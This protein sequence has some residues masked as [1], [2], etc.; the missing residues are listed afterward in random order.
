MHESSMKSTVPSD[1]AL[2]LK[3]VRKPVNLKFLDDF[4]K[5]M[6]ISILD[7]AKVMNI[8][9]QGVYYWFIHDDAS[10][11]KMQELFDA[12]GYD[13]VVSLTRDK[14]EDNQANV[15]MKL[16]MEQEPIFGPRLDFLTKAI[17]TYK[18]KKAEV[19]RK[20]KISATTIYYWQT[21]DDCLLSNLFEFA[22]VTGLIMNISITP[23]GQVEDVVEF[24]DTVTETE[25]EAPVQEDDPRYEEV[26]KTLTM[27]NYV[28]ENFISDA[29]KLFS[30]NV[31]LG[32]KVRRTTMQISDLLKDYRMLSV[33]AEK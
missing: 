31:S 8:S 12:L 15:Q 9:R 11:S 6:S 13:F 26:K 7:I 3:Q 23:K 10:L 4:M 17:K 28:F 32:P 33:E 30:G 21:H 18:I 1:S 2:E 16:A 5:R 27:I 25:I 24:E 22:K 29:D 20:M 19:S 14:S